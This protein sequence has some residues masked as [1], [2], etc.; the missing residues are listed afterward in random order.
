MV[1]CFLLTHL[2]NGLHKMVTL[3]SIQHLPP[4]AFSNSLGLEQP[5]IT[6]N[7]LSQ[8][9][10]SCLAFRELTELRAEETAELALLETGEAGGGRP[11]CE[12]SSCRLGTRSGC[13][14]ARLPRRFTTPPPNSR[15]SRTSMSLCTCEGVWPHTFSL[16]YS[17]RKSLEVYKKMFN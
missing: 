12:N 9:K 16:E 1:L 5:W 8:I 15:S 13:W 11:A 6:E 10:A 7:V 3:Q 2:K 14:A 4:S 17:S